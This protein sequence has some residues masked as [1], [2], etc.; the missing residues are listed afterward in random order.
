MEYK[1]NYIHSTWAG[2]FR[3]RPDRYYQPQSVEEIRFVV[4]NVRKHGRTIMVTGAGH[5]PSR[6]TM[7]S[8]WLVNLDKFN[9]IVK[10]EEHGSDDCKWVDVTVE[11]GIRVFEL[12]KILEERG[13]AI[14]SLGSI[15]DQSIGGIFATGTHGST[16]YH[17][18]VSQQIVDL[19]IMVASGESVFCSPTS[20][21]DLFRAALL[22]LGKL[23]IITHVTIRAV[24]K[25]SLA[26]TVEVVPFKQFL[27]ELWSKVWTSHEFIRVWW[28]P[29]AR[30]C[31]I[32]RANKTTEEPTPRRTTFYD[33]TLGRFF[34]QSLLWVSVKLFPRLT[35]AIERWVFARQF[36]YEHSLGNGD[37]QVFASVEGH[38]MDCLFSQYVNEW[39]M[40]LTEGP[41][42]LRKL[43]KTIDEA[44]ASGEFY[45]NSPFEVRIGNTTTTQSTDPIDPTDYSNQIGAVP[46]NQLRP[47]LD[48]SP[49]LPYAKHPDVDETSLTLFL[50]AT[51]FRPFGWD[52]PIDK[53]Y[54]AFEA[55]AAAAG[56]KPHWAKNYLGTNP[57]TAVSK[58]GEM[59]GLGPVIE[60]W[61][62]EDLVLWKKLRA[63]YDPDGVFLPSK[64]NNWMEINGLLD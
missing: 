44:A 59:R 41:S 39:A 24:P 51:R 38:N 28:F 50:N 55:I 10:Y 3:C 54:S 23:G 22:S 34:Y 58:D 18:N 13:L 15:S 9:R 40:P 31:V 61:Y 17:G 35:P 45:V 14:Q 26:A 12:N 48:P 60:E 4:E 63:Q 52:C 6:L 27:E 20:N 53:W 7:T 30:H 43:E 5:S 57:T 56:G 47:L 49:K 25:Y 33:T 42:V 1:T 36:G 2:T 29:Y 8:D 11:A 62:G 37:H 32:W 21:P 64:D 19:T 16:A 46:G